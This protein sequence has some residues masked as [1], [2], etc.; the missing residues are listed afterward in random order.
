MLWESASFF[1]RD[2]S[3]VSDRKSHNSDFFGLAVRCLLFNPEGP[4]SNPCLCANFL[5]KFFEA[6]D[7][8]VFRQYETPPSPLFGFLRLIFENFLMSPKG[9]PFIFLIYCNRTNVKKFQRVSS[10]RFF[11]T[12]RLLKFRIFFEIFSKKKTFGVFYM[13]LFQFFFIEVP[14]QFLPKMKRFMTVKDSSRFSAL[15]DFKKIACDLQKYFS[16]I[17][18]KNFEKTSKNIFLQ[19]SFFKRFSVEEGR[20]FAVFSW[21]EWFSRL[22]PIASG[23]FWRCKIDEILT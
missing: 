12:M 14:P 5:N 1:P 22:V 20:F 9:P 2:N 23:I 19:F 16:K 7:S 18:W 4:G 10:F 3:L 13:R 15:C 17:F 8:H 21:E 6:E 11:G